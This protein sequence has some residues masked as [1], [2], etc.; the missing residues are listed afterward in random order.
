MFRQCRESEQ[1]QTNG[2]RS[3]LKPPF[4][5]LY[6]NGAQTSNGY[7][8]LGM[9]DLAM[10]NVFRGIFMIRSSGPQLAVWGNWPAA[11]SVMSKP[12]MAKSPEANSNMSGQPLSA[13][14]WAPFAWGSGPSLRRNTI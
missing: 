12:M 3:R 11:R 10:T 5:E 8:W 4:G 6:P 2:I 13:I 14:V 9:S 7:T 1:H